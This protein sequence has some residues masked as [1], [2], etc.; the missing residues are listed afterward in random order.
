[1]DV[2]IKNILDT[3]TVSLRFASETAYPSYVSQLKNKLKILESFNS[4]TVNSHNVCIVVI[5][6]L[7]TKPTWNHIHCNEN[8]PFN[9]FICELKISNMDAT[10]YHRHNHQCRNLQTYHG[11]ECW[12]IQSNTRPLIVSSSTVYSSFFST[13]S[14]WAYGHTI[15]NRIQININSAA[16][17]YC[18]LTHGLP[19][20]FRKTWINVPCKQND[21]YYTLGQ[22]HPTTYKYTCDG[23]MHFNCMDDTCILASYVCDGFYDCPDKSD[24]FNSSCAKLDIQDDGYADFYFF[25]R[26]GRC[27]HV[28]QLCDNWQHCYDGSDEIYCTYSHNGWINGDLNIDTVEPYLIQ[29]IDV[30][31]DRPVLLYQ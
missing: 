21:E 11:G 19:N 26:N 25:C 28:T 17:P 24:E 31:K 23:I 6:T 22:L 18:I 10:T 13:L 20:H 4:S 29:V 8:I 9:H 1:M 5:L 30:K 16:T 2:I 27:I 7:I 14:A 12:L 15:R 3:S